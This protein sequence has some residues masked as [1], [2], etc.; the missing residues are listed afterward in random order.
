MRPRWIFFTLFCAMAM[1]GRFLPLFYVAHHQSDAHIGILIAVATAV[2]VFASPFLCNIADR[3][4][5][6]ERFAALAYA[7]TS[8]AFLAQGV[9]WP[10]AGLVAPQNTFAVLLVLRVLFGFWKAAAYPLVSA[11]AIETLREES[12]EDGHQ[13]FG[14]ERLWGAVSWAACALALGCVL[15]VKGV[16]MWVVHVGVAFFGVVHVIMLLVFERKKMEKKEEA[17]DRQ[18]ILSLEAEDAL[19]QEELEEEDGAP[20]EEKK[21][22]M[23]D[24]TPAS[25]AVLPAV[26]RILTK[27][28]L[29]TILYFNM[30]FWLGFGMSLVENLLFLFFKFDLHASNFVCGLSVV[31]TV[32]FEIPLFAIAPKLLQRVG[33]PALAVIGCF[34]YV[35]RGFGYTIAPNGWVVLLFEPLHGVTFACIETATVAFVAERTPKELAATG[36]AVAAGIKT[37]SVTLGASVGGWGMQR[38]GSKIVYRTGG[39]LVMTAAVAFV[40]GYRLG[41]GK[42]GM[43]NETV[44]KDNSSLEKVDVS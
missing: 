26:Y 41:D 35:V 2:S 7:L 11:I 21:Q 43:E 23:K 39:L 25:M 6:R 42:K 12:G 4:G 10:A 30:A 19:V 20:V 1:P 8:I 9:A 14:E 33:S 24:D 40:L 16:E 27:G 34:A 28:G 22:K 36:Q 18:A 31:I 29:P 38:F 32:I 5:R 17:K 3:S 37:L 13:R 15:D 44:E